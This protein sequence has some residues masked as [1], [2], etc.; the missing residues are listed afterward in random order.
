[1]QINAAAIEAESKAEY[2][3]IEI[4]IAALTFCSEKNPETR[5]MLAK[6][7]PLNSL[8]LLTLSW[9]QVSNNGILLIKI[10][11]DVVY[12]D[13]YDKIKQ[14]I[15]LIFHVHTRYH[16]TFFFSTKII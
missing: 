13:I 1:M 14:K 11:G 5:M 4:T 2:Y 15:P 3:A 8:Q 10:S 7:P 16:T 12:Y 9:A 6:F